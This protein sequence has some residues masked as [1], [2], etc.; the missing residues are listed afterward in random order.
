MEILSKTRL[1][2]K[3]QLCVSDD[4]ITRA[5][6]D[7]C[8]WGVS[9]G[10]EL[11]IEAAKDLCSD[12]F[13]EGSGSASLPDIV[14]SRMA[15]FQKILQQDSTNVEAVLTNLEAHFFKSDAVLALQRQLSGATP[16]SALALKRKDAELAVPTAAQAPSAPK[17]DLSATLLAIGKPKARPPKEPPQ[18]KAEAPSTT[19]HSANAGAADKGGDAG[20]L[21][22]KKELKRYRI[23][24]K[25]FDSAVGALRGALTQVLT[26][27]AYYAA[28]TYEAPLPPLSIVFRTAEGRS[29][30]GSAFDRDGLRFACEVELPRGGGQT[31]S[32]RRCVIEGGHFSKLVDSFSEKDASKGRVVCVGL[33]LNVEFLA[34]MLMTQLGNACS[35]A[36]DVV[37]T[38]HSHGLPA[39][40]E[41]SLQISTVLAQLRSASLR[42]VPAHALTGPTQ[43]DFKGL[44][45]LCKQLSI[46][47]LL[48]VSAH[49][50]HNANVFFPGAAADT[51]SCALLAVE[52]VPAF[53]L[54]ASDRP[55]PSTSRTPP[56]SSS[57][58]AAA[59][60]LDP[61]PKKGAGAKGGTATAEAL[62]LML[63]DLGKTGK[64]SNFR[65]QQLVVKVSAFLYSLLSV[66]YS[67]VEKR[68]ATT[69]GPIVVVSDAKQAALQRLCSFL[70]SA[71]DATSL[72]VDAYM[73][74]PQSAEADRRH[75]KLILGEVKS[76]RGHSLVLYST[77]DDA[78]QI[79][80]V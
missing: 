27:Q 42:A 7:V 60:Q 75:I 20:D 61:L 62:V 12:Y 67:L 28:D 1:L 64:A 23:I 49:D 47:A 59:P 8:L 63:S 44:L 41:D 17:A 69:S 51:S 57:A 31:T 66:Q 39:A 74:L 36:F 80:R 29:R 68:S 70:Q 6:I 53:L 11:T 15:P 2:G 72:T 18:Q 50:A 19:T 73:R 37:V 4:R 10:E 55:R 46:P 22:D 40:H 65:K 52:E 43:R 58:R 5:I 79:L 3:V 78:Y 45:T 54:R 35:A 9:L 34:S 13:R 21:F 14:V 71:E 30:E 77:A 16:V 26:L 32:V 56:S 38:S 33:R 25:S 24:L 48:T 76:L